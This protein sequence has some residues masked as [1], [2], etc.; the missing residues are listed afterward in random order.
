MDV[1]HQKGL[2]AIMAAVA[3]GAALARLAAAKSHPLGIWRNQIYRLNAGA[4]VRVITKRL[5]RTAAAGAPFIGFAL[6]N[7]DVIGK[8]LGYNGLGHSKTP[9]MC[10]LGG[11]KTAYGLRYFRTVNGRYPEW[12][13][14][15]KTIANPLIPDDRDR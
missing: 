1:H 4:F 12:L 6:F 7:F 3:N 13:I 2:Q 15:L 9:C 8:R 10:K 5:L 11:W 14:S